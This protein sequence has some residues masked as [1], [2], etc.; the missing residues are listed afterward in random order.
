MAALRGEVILRTALTDDDILRMYNL[1]LGYFADVDRAQF[2][3]DLR[4]KTWVIQLRDFET[5]F[6]HGFTTLCLMED[7]VQGLPVRA[8]FSGD[9]IIERPYWG[10]FA[11]ERTWIQFI[12][13]QVQAAPQCRWFWF[14]I[15]KGYRT[16]SYLPVYFQ[17]YY[18][19]PL[20]TPSFE[21]TVLDTLAFS[22]FGARYD[23]QSGIIR[24]AN[25][26]R[27]LPGVGDITALVRLDPRIAFFEE[28]NPGWVDGDELACLVELHPDNYRPTTLRMLGHQGALC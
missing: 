15:C 17:R 14:L 21:Q 6:I 1:M 27:L 19:S 13:A 24:S 12:S 18:P 4:E 2:E 11:L 25:D 23:Q 22:R 5:G 9:T 7:V 16:Y 26:Y 10:S 8:V 20:P 28:K 3:G